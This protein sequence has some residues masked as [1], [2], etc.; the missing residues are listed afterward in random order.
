[1]DPQGNASRRLG[2]ED[3]AANSPLTT[4]EVTNL[5]TLFRD[6]VWGV[7]PRRSLLAKADEEAKP[8]SQ[9]TGSHEIRAVY[10]LLAERFEKEVTG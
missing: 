2:W 9:I 5:R 7:V 1:M 6:Q 8:L 3:S 10:E 4:S